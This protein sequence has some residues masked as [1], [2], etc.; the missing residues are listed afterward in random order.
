MP[1]GADNYVPTLGNTASLYVSPPCL[2]VLTNNPSFGA[3][4]APNGTWLHIP[5]RIP[6][7]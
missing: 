7:K 4:Q 6:S 5:E 1:S 2:S 3:E